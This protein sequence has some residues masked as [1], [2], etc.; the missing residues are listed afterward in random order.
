M[1]Q[2]MVTA[3]MDLEMA[4]T[5]LEAFRRGC[6]LHRDSGEALDHLA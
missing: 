6:S 4:E 1:Q 3:G 2:K 5:D